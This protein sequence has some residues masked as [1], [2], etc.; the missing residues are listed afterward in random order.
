MP[1]HAPLSAK[2]LP[3]FATLKPFSVE[4]RIGRLRFLA[5]TM[6]LSW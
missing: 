5:W 4:G 1:R 3:E 2:A 6:V